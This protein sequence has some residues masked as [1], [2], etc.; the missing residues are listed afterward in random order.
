MLC[1]IAIVNRREGGGE[2]GAALLFFLP[3]C[4][5]L[6]YPINSRAALSP[7]PSVLT[8]S[9]KHITQRGR[10]HAPRMELLPSRSRRVILFYLFILFIILLYI[11]NVSQLF[12][13]L[14]GLPLVIPAPFP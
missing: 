7:T 3:A 2:T 13:P 14:P 9:G 12:S 8:P 1:I 5:R 11:Y 4:I 10:L 6:F